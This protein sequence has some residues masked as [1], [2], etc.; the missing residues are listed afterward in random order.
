M[1][2]ESLEQSPARA[3]FALWIYVALLVV[4]LDQ[5]SKWAIVQWVPLYERI[6]VM[7]FLNITHQR[8]EGAAF[9][10]L[11]DASGWQRWLFIAL[12]LGIS[13]VIVVWLWR[14]RAAR[15]FVL[16]SGLALVLGGAIGNVIDRIR[17]GYVVDFV[18]VLIAGWPFPSF[19]VADSAITVGAVLL[20]VDALFFSGK[21]QSAQAEG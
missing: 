6:R 12:A 16:A 5:L 18:Q 11:A 2:D 8:N 19:N 3:P 4:A 10:F 7:P 14:L 20:I 13:T 17:V 9:S 1:T 15:Q 21:Q